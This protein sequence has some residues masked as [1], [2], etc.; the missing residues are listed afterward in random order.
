[1]TPFEEPHQEVRGPQASL[2][3]ELSTLSDAEATLSDLAMPTLDR[4]PLTSADEVMPHLQSVIEELPAAAETPPEGLLTSSDMFALENLEDP[5]PP[6]HLTLEFEP[7]VRPTD[8]AS[9]LLAEA[10]PTRGPATHAIP[11]TLTSAGLEPDLPVVEALTFEDLDDISLPAHLTLELDGSEMASE[12]SSIIL[13][14][15]QLDSP[16]GDT[17]SPLSAHGDQ[18]D[19]EE[20]MLLD[21]DDL[22]LDEDEPA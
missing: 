14:N 13:D 1:M 3:F 22:E 19:D 5:M 6:E 21:L 15:L 7:P 17:Q 20:E 10:E 18:A 8:L 11:E 4:P 12:V 9:N 16:P 2:D